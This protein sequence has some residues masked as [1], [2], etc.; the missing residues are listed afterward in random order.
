MGTVSD[1]AQLHDKATRGEPLSAAERARLDAW[2][3]AQDAAEAAALGRA[4]PQQA[5]AA[6]RTEIAEAATQLEAA[7]QRV[8]NLT[9]GNAALRDEVAALE[10][11]LARRA[12]T[13]VA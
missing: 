3:A 7:A 4:E 1:G 2:Y 6:L 5:V 11:R 12:G 13:R 10:R 8:R 9:A